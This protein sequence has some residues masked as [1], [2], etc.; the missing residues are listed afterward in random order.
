MKPNPKTN[1]RSS[2]ILLHI[3]SLPSKY[4]I[5]DLGPDAY[6][7]VDFLKTARQTYWQILP[8]NPTNG[9]FSHSSY[10]SNSAFACNPLFISP[11]LLLEEEW[12][13][14][15]DLPEKL[16]N[17]KQFVD[18][19]MAVA[20]KEKILDIAFKKFQSDKPAHKGFDQFCKQNQFWLNDYALFLALK[21]HFQNLPWTDWPSMVKKRDQKTLDDLAYRYGEEIEKAKFVQYV[22]HKQWT[23]LKAYCHKSGI[24]IL[25]DLPIYVNDD[26][27]D[28]WMHPEFFKLNADMKPEVVAGVPPDYFSATGQRWGNPVY[29][30]ER[31]QQTGYQWWLERLR[32]NFSL[33]DV[34]RIDH[35]RGLIAFWEIPS[36]EP[37]AVNGHWENVPWDDFFSTIK[38]Q[39]K[40]LPIIAEDLGIITP[41]VVEAMKKFGFPGMKVLLF[42]FDSDS[43]NP[44]LPN[45]YQEDCVV[46]TGTHDNNT[47]RGWFEHEGSHDSKERFF[48]YVGRHVSADE[49]A[50]EMVRLA[51]TSAANLS[52]VPIQDV[53]G[54]GQDARMNTPATT[55]GNWRWRL[56]P[57][58]VSSEVATNL[59]KLTLETK[60]AG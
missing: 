26:S 50:W 60:R 2:G 12:L 57:N 8:L 40:P 20:F 6:K 41:D 21:K 42:A 38:K 15:K 30:W 4:G 10:S 7:F 32:R 34:V 25:G 27:V 49:A 44:Y 11:E 31:L 17:S 1:P 14:K 28:V 56:I 46:Y 39:F 16:E 53:L 47:A 55:H 45:N 37:T 59:A 51:M 33:F 54:L 35:F 9:I 29:R 18:Y 3:S 13:S 48:Q 5:G 24:K 43:T 58:A 22:F 36:Q 23:D 19:E 52:I